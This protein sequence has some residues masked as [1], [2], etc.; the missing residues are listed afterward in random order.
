MILSSPHII[1]FLSILN[2]S[3]RLLIFRLMLLFLSVRTLPIITCDLLLIYFSA[4]HCLH[5]RPALSQATTNF[6]LHHEHLLPFPPTWTH[7]RLFSKLE[8]ELPLKYQLDHANL[9]LDP[10]PQRL[11]ISLQGKPQVLMRAC[12]T[13][14]DHPIISLMWLSLPSS[15]NKEQLQLHWPC[16]R[17]QALACLRLPSR[18]PQAPSSSTGLCFFTRPFLTSLLKI[19][20]LPHPNMPHPCSLL[21]FSPIALIIFQHTIYFAFNSLSPLE[22][23]LHEGWTCISLVP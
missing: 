20:T 4:Y 13:L 12:K 3:S 5:G 10:I 19:S 1:V 2:L 8:S 9:F 22:C 14:H 23:E 6:Q 11:L 16:G 21:C 18:P 7:H 15:L 17:L